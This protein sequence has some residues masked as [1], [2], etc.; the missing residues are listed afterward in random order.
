M[1]ALKTDFPAF[2]PRFPWIGGDLQTLRNYLTPG[3]WDLSPWPS[4][5]LHFTAEDGSGDRMQGVLHLQNDGA[6]I[7]L[8]HG[9]TGCEESF[10]V[11]ETARFLLSRGHNVLRLN[12][13]GAGPSRQ[14]CA[15]HYCAGSS[16]DVATVLRNLPE[17][18]R[19]RET[20][21]V[22]YS[23]GGNVILKYLAESGDSSGVS[24]ATVVS[25]P[26][27]L[28]AASKRVM[29]P[30]NRLYHRWLLDRM[31]TEAGAGAAQLSKAEKEAISLARTVYEFDDTFVAPRNG[32]GG[33]EDY[34]ARCSAMDMLG[35]I[36]CPTLIVHARNDPWIPDAAFASLDLSRFSHIDLALVDG[37][38]H[39]G[40]HGADRTTPWHNTCIHTYVR[41]HVVPN[42]VT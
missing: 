35:A 38:G 31:A 27:D 4:E 10:Y 5:R 19:G 17:T 24:C 1:S 18:L 30:R 33:A 37:G 7:L 23:L 9:L 15:G 13:R 22:G 34:Y 40:F 14:T 12:L 11:L 20:V 32:F 8:L 2:R 25:P 3:G 39:V 42:R 29:A 26:I 21:L 41:R 28:A 16:A 6:V 36:E